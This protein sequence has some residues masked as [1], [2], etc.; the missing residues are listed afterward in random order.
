MMTVTE[1]FEEFVTVL[2]TVVLNVKR[3]EYS[4]ERDAAG[5]VIFKAI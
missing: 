1:N 5:R 4:G 2:C 3:N